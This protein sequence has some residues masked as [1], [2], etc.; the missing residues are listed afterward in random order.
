M[1]SG[2]LISNVPSVVVGYHLHTALHISIA[3]A[4]DA[5]DMRTRVLVGLFFPVYIICIW[6]NS[7]EDSE[8]ALPHHPECIFCCSDW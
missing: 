6:I 7:L 4:F 8:Y 1:V 3:P 2:S 5:N